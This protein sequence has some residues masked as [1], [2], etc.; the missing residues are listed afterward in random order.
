[1]S[2]GG[3][4]SSVLGRGW[5]CSPFLSTPLPPIG[6]LPQALAPRTQPVRSAAHS[7]ALC[8]PEASPG[9]RRVSTQACW[10]Q[11]AAELA[12][13]LPGDGMPDRVT[14]ALTDSAGALPFTLLT[15]SPDQRSGGNGSQL[16]KAQKS[17]PHLASLV[18]TA[19]DAAKHGD[20]G[21]AG[22]PSGV[23]RLRL[24]R[25]HILLS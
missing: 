22:T 8:P 23:G 15:R 25:L 2:R 16:L 21:R 20:Q 9:P 5:Q 13:P 12:L 1:M 24:P 3:V 14:W 4:L 17:R 11:S 6:C 7:S 10:G 18:S 19:R